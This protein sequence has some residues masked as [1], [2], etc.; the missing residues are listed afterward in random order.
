MIRVMSM[1]VLTASVSL[2]AASAVWAQAV[3]PVPEKAKV[4]QPVEATKAKDGAASSADPKDA[5]KPK[6]GF[7]LDFKDL[8]DLRKS[9]IKLPDVDDL[10]ATIPSTK[11]AAQTPEGQKDASKTGDATKPEEGSKEGEEGEEDNEPKINPGEVAKA[12]IEGMDS[13]A[14]RLDKM[15]DPGAE[16]QGVQ[17][18]VV[19]DLSAL[20]KYVAQQQQQSQSQSKSKSQQKDS[21]KSQGKGQ[22]QSQS[23]SQ[24]RGQKPQRGNQAMKDSEA[25]HG[26]VPPD[27]DP[28]T[29]TKLLSESWGNL[30]FAPSKETMQAVPEMVLEKYRPL[31]NSY[32]YAL[33]R[34]RSTAAPSSS[35]TGSGGN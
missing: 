9:D 23:R 18:K 4:E 30:P 34:Q 27:H 6:E 17:K 15:T 29:V 24:G 10:P 13:S 31:L 11:D 22:G 33:A 20:I 28:E 3:E 2:L 14:Q 16:T 19:D 12:I 32:Y 21:Q 26:E 25:T 8:K 5:E 1:L 7:S 35:G